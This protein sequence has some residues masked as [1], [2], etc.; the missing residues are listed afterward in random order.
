[1]SIGAF[2]I[3]HSLLGRVLEVLSSEGY[4]KELPSGCQCYNL[5]MRGKPVASFATFEEY[6]EFEEKSL[7]KHEYVD[8]KVYLLH[9]EV[10][11]LSSDQNHFAMTGESDPHNLI[12][13]NIFSQVRLAARGTPCRAYQSDMKLLVGQKAYYP[14]VLLTCHPDDAGQSAK[15]H[16]CFIVEVLSDST[17]AID[18]IEKFAQYRLLGNLQLY[19]LVHQTERHLEYYRKQPSGECVNLRLSFAEIYEDVDMHE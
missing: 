16:P 10:A 1:V 19:V 3:R 2:T 17:E 14:D 8:G 12:G 7:E 11:F 13:G 18:R 5:P 6:L 9:D 4:V 15:Q